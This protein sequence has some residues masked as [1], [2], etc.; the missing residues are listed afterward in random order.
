[1]DTLTLPD[2]HGGLPP[3]A[4]ALCEQVRIG[5]GA[6]VLDLGQG[7]F[8]ILH[9]LAERVGPSGEVVGVDP[10]RGR[11]AAVRSEVA[12][13]RFRNVTVVE[14]HPADTALPAGSFD[15]VHAR[16]VLSHR[17]EPKAVLA[18]MIRLVR[19]GGWVVGSQ[20][21]AAP[22]QEAEIIPRL[23]ALSRVMGLT[24]V[25]MDSGSGHFL[26]WALRP[27]PVGSDVRRR[28][29]RRPLLS[30]VRTAWRDLP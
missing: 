12:E 16:H 29:P 17:A 20:A 11:V 7:P 4:A 9:L 10:D 19:P 25:G 21:G 30:N 15:V 23:R 18:E 3:Y 22:A 8:D 2:R 1:M 13:V 5:P 28:V 27:A 24:E 26:V 6:R 14:G